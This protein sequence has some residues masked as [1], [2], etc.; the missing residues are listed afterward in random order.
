M[1]QDQPRVIICDYEFKN[2]L[3]C[4]YRSLD[5]LQGMYKADTLYFI[6][7]SDN[8]LTFQQ[9]KR[10]EYILNTYNLLIIQRKGIDIGNTLEKYQGYHGDIKFIDL[11][12]L[13]LSSNQIRTFLYDEQYDKV[14]SSLDPYVLDYIKKKKLYS[15]YYIEEPILYQSDEEFLKII[16][17][18]I[19]RK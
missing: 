18:M 5:Y 15:K 10:Y 3:I 19:M 11:D 17:V 12:L 1:F 2:N 9:W 16:I 14:A 13:E 7:G 6:M 8:L 4:T